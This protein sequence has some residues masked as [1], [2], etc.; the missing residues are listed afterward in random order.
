[1][2]EYEAAE[3]QEKKIEQNT[4][5]IQN[6]QSAE[7]SMTDSA[8]RMMES[9]RKTINISPETVE[10]DRKLKDQQRRIAVAEARQRVMDNLPVAY[11]AERLQRLQS[12]SNRVV[13][14]LSEKQKDKKLSKS[15]LK[16]D[17]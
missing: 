3:K 11:D 6:T 15:Q 13:S 9:L 2:K 7:K 16:Q 4:A 12:R 8:D 5:L 17:L 1:M 14:D 10:A